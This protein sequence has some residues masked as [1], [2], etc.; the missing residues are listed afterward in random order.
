MIE[1]FKRLVENIRWLFNHPPI[2]ITSKLP[3]NAKCNYCAMTKNLLDFTDSFTICFRC[4]K[5]L[6]DKV[7]LEK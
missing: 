6:C 4:L 5:Q 2:N 3:D 7:L 1:L